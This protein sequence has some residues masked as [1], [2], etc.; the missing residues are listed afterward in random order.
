[1]S[2]IVV[3]FSEYEYYN[4]HEDENWVRFMG[5]TTKG[6]YYV[7]RPRISAMSFREDKQKFRDKTLEAI[8]AGL[9][10]GELALD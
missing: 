9:N 5:T 10:P 4:I 3:R 8:D 6:T 2:E 7:E 1:M